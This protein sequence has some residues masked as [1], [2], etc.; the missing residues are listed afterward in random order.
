METVMISKTTCAALAIAMIGATA[1]T[2]TDAFAFRP[3]ARVA[4]FRAM[5]RHAAVT[6]TAHVVKPTRTYSS[7]R[8]FPPKINPGS[9]TAFVR[10]KWVMPAGKGTK[11]ADA[12]PVK[13]APYRTPALPGNKVGQ[14]PGVKPGPLNRPALPGDKLGSHIPTVP[15]PN[16][17]GTPNPGGNNWPSRPWPSGPG[18]GVEMQPSPVTVEQPSSVSVPAPAV[19]VERVMTQRPV[20]VIQRA[21]DNG[22]QACAIPPLAAAIDALLPTAPLSATDRALVSA[23]RTAI[24]DLA[25]AGNEPG[26]RELEAKA[27]AMFGYQKMW[28]AC[29]QGAFRWEKLTM[30]G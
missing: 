25:A 6:R 28:L 12:I 21:A 27:M 11:V 20:S 4:S 18:G 26:A 29:G 5:P 19:T 15:G 22:A 9:V 23:L 17:P 7:P 16:N 2:T 24:A 3:S 13:P 30:P 14:L 10:P 8:L 1:L